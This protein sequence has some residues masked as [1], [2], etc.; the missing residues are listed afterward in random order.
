[1]AS[2]QGFEFIGQRTDKEYIFISLT[3]IVLFLI[4]ATLSVAQFG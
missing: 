3:T 4:F 2:E 1:M